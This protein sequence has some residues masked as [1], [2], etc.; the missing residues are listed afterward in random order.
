MMLSALRRFSSKSTINHI[1]NIRI[2]VIG[3]S[4]FGKDV[5]KLLQSRGHEIVGV[6]TVPDVNGK[7]D[8]LAQAAE[9]DGVKVFKY[10]RWRSKGVAIPAV[11]EE[12]K[13]CNAELNVLPFCSQ[14]IPSEVIDSPANGSIIYHPSILPRHRGASAINWTLIEGDKKAGFTIFYADDGLDTGPMLLTKECSVHP[15]DTVDS[16]YNRFLYPQGVLA[17]GEAV[18]LIEKGKAPKIVQ[19]TEGATYDPMMKKP[20]AKIDWSKSAEAVHNFIRGCD[21]VPGAWTTVGSDEVTL[22]GSSLWTKS[23]DPRG[24][25]VPFSTDLPQPALRHRDGLLITCADGKK[26]NVS[27]LSIN[28]KLV[29][30]SKFGSMDQVGDVVLNDEEITLSSKIQEIWA[31]I[32][33]KKPAEIEGDTDFFEAGAASM[34]VTRLVEE[35]RDTTGVDMRS[36]HVYMATTLTNS[37]SCLPARTGERQKQSSPTMRSS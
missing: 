10:Q 17:M 14:F 3:Q 30:A 18:D 19:P 16:I 22:F 24:D 36:E 26:V 25:Q 23:R 21:M 1:R 28:G 20:I 37:C 13:S 5:Y 12:F 32:L 29:L 7:P 34:D 27:S 9:A 2:A 11:V 35:V 4:N 6:F 15:T 33:N 8:P 31:S